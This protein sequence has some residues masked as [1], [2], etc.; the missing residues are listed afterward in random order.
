MARAPTSE[1]GERG[2]PGETSSRDLVRVRDARATFL[3]MNLRHTSIH[4][5]GTM[6]GPSRSA[7]QPHAWPHAPSCPLV[8]RQIRSPAQGRGV[9]TK[10]HLIRSLASH[11]IQPL[12]TAELP[13]CFPRRRQPCSPPS[14]RSSDVSHQRPAY[15]MSILHPRMQSEVIRAPPRGSCDDAAA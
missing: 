12:S 14:Q 7:R 2:R 3:A 8:S 13:A 11:S 1:R 4:R 6:R 10:A 15:H 9:R 5:E